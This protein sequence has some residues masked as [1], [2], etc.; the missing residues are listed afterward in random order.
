MR[1]E[2]RPSPLLRLR[3]AGTYYVCQSLL[4]K[5]KGKCRNPRLNAKRFEKLIVDQ[6][7]ENILTESNI[8]DLVKILDEE[9][10][11][12]AKEQR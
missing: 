1:F 9:M 5:G 8:K 2:A 3:A 12:I 11:G 10:D 4:K 6:I 7:R